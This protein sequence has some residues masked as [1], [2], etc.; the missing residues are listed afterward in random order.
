M[1]ALRGG[2]MGLVPRNTAKARSNLKTRKTFCLTELSPVLPK[3]APS[4]Q[5]L[6]LAPLSLNTD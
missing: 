2:E 1:Q 5:D 3:S 4:S 6:D